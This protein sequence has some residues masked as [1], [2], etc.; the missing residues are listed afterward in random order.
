MSNLSLT[1]PLAFFAGSPAGLVGV[2]SRKRFV[3]EKEMWR[4]RVNLED[5][6]EEREETILAF[7]HFMMNYL[8]ECCPRDAGKVSQCDGHRVSWTWFNYAAR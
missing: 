7:W 3:A 5:K 2:Y 1:L 4:C 6:G 8:T